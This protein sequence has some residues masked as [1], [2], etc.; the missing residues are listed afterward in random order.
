MISYTNQLVVREF[1][2]YNRVFIAITKQ[3]NQ[4]VHSFTIWK[5]VELPN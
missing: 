1:A 2:D 5:I 3:P 4:E